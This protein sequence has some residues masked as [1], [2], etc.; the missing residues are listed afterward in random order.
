MKQCIFGVHCLGGCFFVVDGKNKTF[1]ETLKYSWFILIRNSIT[2]YLE[3]KQINLK[4]FF[5][6]WETARQFGLFDKN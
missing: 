6:L 3:L 2:T 4:E 5:K 1:Y